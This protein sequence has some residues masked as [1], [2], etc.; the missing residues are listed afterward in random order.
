[1]IWGS[2]NP[3]AVHLSDNPCPGWSGCGWVNT[4][5][6]CG[7]SSPNV[8]SAAPCAL[9]NSLLAMHCYKKEKMKKMMKNK[10]K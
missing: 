8:I 4:F 1:M 9:S 6:K 10:I 3:V 2:G 7:G 5:V